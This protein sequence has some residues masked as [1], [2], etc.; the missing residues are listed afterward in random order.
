MEIDHSSCEEHHLK[1]LTRE[2]VLEILE[3]M[4]IEF[5]PVYIHYYNLLK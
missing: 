5:T 2:K 3:R 4:R 1:V